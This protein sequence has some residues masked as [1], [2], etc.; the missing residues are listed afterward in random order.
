MRNSEKK[1]IIKLS[2][3]IIITVLAMTIFSIPLFGTQLLS[4]LIPGRGIW[5]VTGEVPIRERLE[6]P[7]LN[8]EV[9]VIRDEWG[10]P[11]IYASNDLDLF[12]A[13]GY[14]HAQDRFF[15]MDMLRRLVRGRISEILGSDAIS[16][17]KFNLAMGMEFWAIRTDEIL[18]EMQA[19]GTIDFLPT[20]DRYVDG[21]NYYLETHKQDKPLEYYILGFEPTEW[22]SIDS[23]CL[24]QEMAR[25]MSWNY[26]DLYRLTSLEALGFNNYIQLFNVILP[27]QIP[28]CPNYG[29][30]DETPKIS[31]KGDEINPLL[32]RTVLDFLENVKESDYEK[33]RMESQ[34][35]VGSNNWV[36]NGVKSNTGKPILANDMHL[37]WMTPGIWYEQHLIST[38]TDINSYGFSIPGMPLIAVGHNQYVGWGFTNTGYDVLDWYYYNIINETHYIYNNTE[39]E[40]ITRNYNISVRDSPTKQFTVRETVHGPVI[41]DFN[42]LD[43]PSSYGDIVLA[44]QWT[45]NDIFLNFLAGYGFNRAKNRTEFD[46]ASQY[47]DTLSQNI[48]YADIDGNIAIRPTGKVPIRDDSRIPPGHLGNGTI[49]YN[50]SNG[51]GEWI[52]YIPFED[53]P[54]TINPTQNY[55]ASA[56]QIIAGP[57]WN[58]SKYFLQNEYSDGYR[59]RRINNL[60]SNAPNGTLS[61]EKMKEYQFDVNSPPAQV[62]IPFLIDV[63]KNQYGLTPPP[64]IDNILTILEGWKYNMAKDLAAPTIYHKWCDYFMNRTFNDEFECY[65][66]E[67]KPRL[68]VLEYLMKEKETSYWFDNVSTLSQIETR[69]E[70][71]LLALNDTIYWLEDFYGSSNPST[72]KWG[73]IHKHYFPHITELN[74]FSKGPYSGDGEEYTLNPSW[75]NIDFGV[76]FSQ[77]GASGRMVLDFSN[78][79]NS[80]SVIASGERGFPNSKHY[81]DQLEQLFLQGKYHIQYFGYTAINFPKSAIESTINFIP[82]GGA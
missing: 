72:W 54:N 28:I 39:T 64:K 48:V 44:P 40:F 12:F 13:Q 18:R 2:I 55:I 60:L 70:I 1:V 27:Y 34:N 41:S 80:V 61:V 43:L 81:S 66:I 67:Q 63:I 11:H 58:Y 7:E 56:N 74:A 65:G 38:E 17:D 9:T 25:Q 20:M 59:A 36:V 57:N 26:N 32:F 19:N 35:N 71:M 4:I 22:T 46:E 68:V 47:W 30:Y 69:N 8:D 77:G 6:I 24:V 50:G 51:E 37:A 42:D 23:L 79:N 10:I 76:S 16:T 49:P 73:K 53:L 45:A 78:L 31:G 52:G 29:V 82:N 5:N 33:K 15:Q 21:I 14:V 75:V 3:I 62:F